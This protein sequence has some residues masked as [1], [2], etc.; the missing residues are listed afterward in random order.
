M[1]L[2]SR[3][4]ILLIEVL[5]FSPLL[6]VDKLLSFMFQLVLKLL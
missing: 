5:L 4:I 2:S 6:G 1:L 3:N